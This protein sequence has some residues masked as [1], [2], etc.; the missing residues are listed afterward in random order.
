MSKQRIV[1]KIS[2]A[3]L[4]QDDNSI[5]DVNKINDLAK[6]I[7]EI[8]KKYIVSIV[9]GGGNIWRGHIA[10]ELGM[11]RNL[12]DNMG[13]MATIINGLALE[14]ALNN[15][16]VDAIVLSAIKCDKLVYES[17]AN[18]IKKAIEK[19]QVM[20]FVGGTGFPYFTTDSCAAIKAAETESSIILMGKNG[21]DGVYDSDPKTNPNAQFYQHITFN[22][23]LTKNL[24]VMD[25]TALALC[26]ENDINLL[27]FNIDKPNAI[28][29][30]LEKKIKH[31]IVSK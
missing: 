18:N 6:Q 28:V 22:M 23:A 2:G 31:T 29:D 1:I 12:A 27:V 11:N 30:V 13:M 21:V 20:I 19:E 8:S 16:N 4:R 17:S 14:N 9:L 5:I 26:Q 7:K 3:C 15:Y 25:A 24:K 10:K